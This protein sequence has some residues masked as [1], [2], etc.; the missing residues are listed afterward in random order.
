MTSSVDSSSAVL[1]ET[2]GS[3]VEGI[4]SCI[5]RALIFSCSMKI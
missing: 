5:L 3:I 1:W 2:S 4:P